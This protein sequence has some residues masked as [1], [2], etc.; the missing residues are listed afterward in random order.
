[1]M[2]LKCIISNN[3]SSNSWSPEFLE[4]SL[5]RKKKTT[6]KEFRYLRE[7]VPAMAKISETGEIRSERRG[8]AKRRLRW[9]QKESESRSGLGTVG[10]FCSQL[11]LGFLPTSSLGPQILRITLVN[12]LGEQQF[13]VDGLFKK[14]MPRIRGK[15]GIKQ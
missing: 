15:Y 7:R 10:T 5:Q 3:W 8:E 9:G 11:A 1:M 13:L 2:R 12:T 4:N 6:L 14:N